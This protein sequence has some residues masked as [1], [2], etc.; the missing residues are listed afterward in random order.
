MV[1]PAYPQLKLWPNTLQRLDVDP[2]PLRSVRPEL[3]KRALPLGK[4]FAAESLAPI[5]L[6][7]LRS[8]NTANRIE[9]HAVEGQGKIG[10]I[11]IHTYGSQFVEGLG[12]EVFYFEN[13]AMLVAAL[14]I[15]AIT[16]PSRHFMLAELIDLIEEDVGS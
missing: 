3:E 14:P 8:S 9:L 16:R 7:I 10:R 15:N 4:S 13:L 5:R 2:G 11:G 12:S 1:W 6:Y